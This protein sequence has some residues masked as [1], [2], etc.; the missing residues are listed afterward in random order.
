MFDEILENFKE[1]KGIGILEKREK[2]LEFSGKLKKKVF[3][4][5]SSWNFLKNLKEFGDF[6]KFF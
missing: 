1:M 5:R 2:N 3:V 4:S 6:S